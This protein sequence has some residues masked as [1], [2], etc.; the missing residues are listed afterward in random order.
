M[1]TTVETMRASDR[2]HFLWLRDHGLA[3]FEN[4]TILDLGCG[5]GYL[6]SQAAAAGAKLAV[7]VDIES[8]PLASST[9]RYLS[10][11]L[12]QDTWPE[13]VGATEFDLVLAFDIIEHLRSPVAFVEGCRALLRSGGRLVLTTPNVNSWER[14]MKP[15]TWSGSQDPQHRILFSRYSLAFLLEKAGFHDIQCSAPMRSLRALGKLQPH[16]GGQILCVATRS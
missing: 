14:L 3:D 11:N 7:G 9:W 16:C 13:T 8:P 12:D 5:S 15:R 10:T 4:R 6:C 1:T 2:D